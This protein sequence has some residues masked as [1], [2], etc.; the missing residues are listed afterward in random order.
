MNTRVMPSASA[1][2]QA[3]WPPAP[4]KQQSVYSV[5][6]WP[7]CDRD[8]L[9]RVRHVLDGDLEEA[10][11]DSLRAPGVPVAAPISARQRRELRAHDRGVERLVA[12]RAEDCGKSVG[13]DLAE[14]HVAV[15]DGERPAAPVAGRPG[16]RA[17]R[18]RADAEARAVEMQDRA[19]ARRDG[20]DLHHRRAQRTPATSVSKRALELAGVVRHVGRG[21]AHVEADDLVEAR[22][23][24]RCD[25]ADDAARRARTGS[26]PCPGSARARSRP[27]IRLHEHA[28]ARRGSSPATC[29]T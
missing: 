1:T 7:R 18:V 26:R 2:A 15:G 11:G 10:F 23:P 12:A 17:G 13:L 21:A 27:P 28:A 20:V 24:R 22:Q 9:D 6:S 8:L 29:S 3:C 14:H 19:A 16:I 25:H 4:P 5:T